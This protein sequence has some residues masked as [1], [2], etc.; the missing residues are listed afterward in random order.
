[1]VFPN[2]PGRQFIQ[3]TVGKKCDTYLDELQESLRDNCGVEASLQTVWRALKR[4]GY[5]MKKVC[6]ITFMEDIY[7]QKTKLTKTAIERSAAKRAAYM[8]K[9][10]WNYTPEQ[11][12]F[13][14]ESACNRKMA[15]RE[16][17]WAIRGRRAVRKAFF[18]RG[19]RYVPQSR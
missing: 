8:T 7:L 3:G 6:L 9:V 18:V 17:A 12:V 15:Y 1:M 13:V 4:S 16:R 14:D 19:R 11:L 5:S 10:G 2:L